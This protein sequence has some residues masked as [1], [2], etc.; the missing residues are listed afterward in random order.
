[1]G[2]QGSLFCEVE[3]LYRNN[4]Q[5][6]GEVGGNVVSWKKGK[7]PHWRLLVEFQ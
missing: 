6:Q 7:F 2:S 3:T 4:F 5:G 1:L